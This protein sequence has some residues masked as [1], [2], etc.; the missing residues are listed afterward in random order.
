[1]NANEAEAVKQESEGL[2][3]ALT[4][5]QALGAQAGRGV[6]IEDSDFLVLPKGTELRNVMEFASVP[7]R[8]KGGATVR[9][10]D[11]FIEYVKRFHDGH[12][13]VFTPPL[14]RI[15]PE[16][17]HGSDPDELPIVQGFMNYSKAGSA[18]W[19]DLYCNLQPQWSPGWLE[20]M[21]INRKF[22]S[23]EGFAEF[24]FDHTADIVEPEAARMLE[25]AQS[26]QATI[27]C[28]F[29]AAT[30][31]KDGQIGFAYKEDMNAT[32][33]AKGEIKIPEAVIVRLTPFI[34][35]VSYRVRG[36]LRYR[37]NRNQGSVGW[38]IVF[39]GM[40]EVIDGAWKVLLDKVQEELREEDASIPFF[41]GE[42]A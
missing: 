39:P 20:W 7:K 33:G 25:V 5:A 1:M 15:P 37:I 14:P 9:D 27:T 17:F 40:Q 36:E 18:Q 8:P 38:G 41:G 34:G 19:E 22:L 2:S 30:R 4:M 23:Q 31:L 42:K 35:G 28:G 12:T 10:A 6:R 29:A 21:A 11:S 24:V 16:T 26:M 32:A 13:V 3:K